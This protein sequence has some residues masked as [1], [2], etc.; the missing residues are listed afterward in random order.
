MLTNKVSNWI[1]LMFLIASLSFLGCADDDVLSVL[2]DEEDGA[3]VE[4]TLEKGLRLGEV[5]TI[6]S[7]PI[8][9][10]PEGIALDKRGNIYVSNR[11]TEGAG[12]VNEILRITRHGNVSVFATLP[13][14]VPEAEGVLGLTTDRKGNVYAAL[15]TN[16]PTTQ[17]VYRIRRNGSVEH[18]PGSEVISF[19]NSLAFDKHRNLYVTDSFVG[20]VWRIGRD[21]VVELWVQDELLEPLPEDP[22]GFP[23]PG[24]NGIAFYPPNHLYVANTEKG[25]IAHIP[26]ERHGGNAGTPEIVA[27]GW[28]LFTIDGIAVDKQGNIH[29]VVPGF[30]IL[31]TLPH[32]RVNPTTGVVTPTVIEPGDIDKFD[33]PLSLAFGKGRDKKSVFVTNGDLPLPGNPLGDPGPG[34]VQ[35]GVGVRGL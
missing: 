32:V 16:D 34:V 14:S 21:G 12:R 3:G 23:V 5:K 18:L 26:I 25:L 8:G 20:S 9:D 13:A 28:D 1:T 24:A 15:V 30:T 35:V 2:P 27:E 17:G 22:L 4:G 6:L 10:N 31:G 7:L 33:V 29:G 11:R 19:A